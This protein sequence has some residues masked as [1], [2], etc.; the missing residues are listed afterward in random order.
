MIISDMKEIM[1]E[2]FAIL[3]RFSIFANR[4]K[5]REH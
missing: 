5:K 1:K 3:N 2:K 4:N